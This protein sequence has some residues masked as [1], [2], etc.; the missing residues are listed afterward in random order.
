MTSASLAMAWLQLLALLAAEVGLIAL[1][2]ALLQRW[3]PAAAWRRTFCQ[4]GIT[5][6]LVVTACELSG[7]ARSL[8]G[9][10]AR[11]LPWGKGENLRT[12]EAYA[13]IKVGQGIDTSP[14]TPSIPMNRPVVGRASRLPP[15]RLALDISIAGETPAPLFRSSAAGARP[16]S[17]GD[18]A[19]APPPPTP[20]RQAFPGNP[21]TTTSRSPDP[22]TDSMGVLWLCLV[23]AVGATLAGT[24]ACLA[25]CLFMIFQFRRRPVTGRALAEKVRTLARTLGIKRRVRVIESARLTSPIAFGLLRPTVGLPPDFA[26]RFNPAKQ[27]AMLA[28]ELAHL[29]AHDPFW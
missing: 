24:R 21:V 17:A 12:P 4:V 23:W 5:A 19:S 13:A 15:V 2:V 3:S 18:E 8:G 9:W 26:I 1:G 6:V 27:D 25:H 10:A 22:V 11:T 16:R 28:H 20:L 29:A 7:S 14:L